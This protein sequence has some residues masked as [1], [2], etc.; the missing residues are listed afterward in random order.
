MQ[1]STEYCI[2]LY[3]MALKAEI[4]ILLLNSDKLKCHILKSHLKHGLSHS[5]FL[6][7]QNHSLFMYVLRL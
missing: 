5:I 7:L 4:L 1:N 3:Y 6:M 2:R